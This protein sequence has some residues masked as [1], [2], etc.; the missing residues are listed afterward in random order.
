[1]KTIKYN[2]EYIQFKGWNISEISEFVGDRLL[3]ASSEHIIVGSSMGEMVG[4][5]GDVLVAPTGNI[6]ASMGGADFSLFEADHF[7]ERFPEEAMR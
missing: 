2:F 3:Y 5:V 4:R 6:S 1:M 7:N